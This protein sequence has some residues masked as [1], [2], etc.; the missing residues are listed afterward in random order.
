MK[1]RDLIRMLEQ[2]GWKLLRNGAKHDVYA[3][4]EKMEAVP[5]HREIDEMLAR[6]IISRQGLK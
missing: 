1:R 3:K 5:R 2:N 4:G 6:A